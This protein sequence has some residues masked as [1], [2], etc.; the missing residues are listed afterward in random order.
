MCLLMST[1]YNSISM[2]MDTYMHIYIRMHAHQYAK[3][4]YTYQDSPN[5]VKHYIHSRTSLKPT[6]AHIAGVPA[7]PQ[8]GL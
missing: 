7:K 8:Q 6:T 1:M 3:Y 4:M 2:H 5:N